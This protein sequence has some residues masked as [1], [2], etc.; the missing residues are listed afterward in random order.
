MVTNVTCKIPVDQVYYTVWSAAQDT[1]GKQRGEDGTKQTYRK[2]KKNRK[3]E[4]G[5]ERAG[6]KRPASLPQSSQSHV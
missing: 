3:V 1:L 5:Y 6:G 2:I 4:P